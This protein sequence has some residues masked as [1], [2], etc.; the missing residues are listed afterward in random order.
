MN[1]AIDHV[2]EAGLVKVKQAEEEEE[3]C[4]FGD[5]EWELL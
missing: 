5:G 3:F 4:R 2:S 1:A